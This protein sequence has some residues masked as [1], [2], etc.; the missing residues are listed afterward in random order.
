MT[1]PHGSQ[2]PDQPRPTAPS[3]AEAPAVPPARRNRALGLSFLAIV[4]LA[5]LAVPRV[6]LHDLH[7]I[8]EGTFVNALLVFV[9]LVVWIAVVLWRRVPNPFLTL[10]VVGACYG[11]F[12][13]AVHLLLWNVAMAGNEPALGGNLVDV[14]PTV[15]AFV[16]RA[17]TVVSSLFTG[18]I[19]GAVTGLV[20]WGIAAL[21]R[22]NA[23]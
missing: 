1:T 15:Q 7:L 17:Y 22:R 4:G 3:A 16:F 9:P 6:V 12:L 11:V 2:H 8:D 5:L 10:L 23:H 14:D 20:A 13:A 19:A 18:L 21:S